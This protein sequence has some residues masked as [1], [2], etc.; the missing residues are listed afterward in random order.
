MKL[1]PKKVEEK[2]KII[3]YVNLKRWWYYTKCEVLLKKQ[4]KI[5][6]NVFFL[7]SF[8]SYIFH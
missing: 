7:F 4:R 5:K 1:K 2:N 8:F 6:W 3:K